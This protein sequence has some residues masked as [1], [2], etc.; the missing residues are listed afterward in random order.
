MAA[1]A[2]RLADMSYRTEL[3][4]GKLDPAHMEFEPDLRSTALGTR[5]HVVVTTRTQFEKDLWLAQMQLSRQ[6]FLL[7]GDLGFG[8]WA[9]LNALVAT[10]DPS[11]PQLANLTEHLP[12]VELCFGSQG[13]MA[14]GFRTVLKVDKQANTID[15][16]HLQGEPAVHG[17]VQHPLTQVLAKRG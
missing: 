7:S 8:T 12:L 6:L 1:P 4:A 11:K 15:A 14:A 9:L 10:V 17:D 2:P 3:A 13:A 16:L 5:F